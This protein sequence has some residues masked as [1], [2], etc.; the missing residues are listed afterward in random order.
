MP[1]YLCLQRSLSGVE[2]TESSEA[3]QGSSS[4][5]DM[6]EMYERFEEWREQYA[7]NIEDAGG[8]LAEGVFVTDATET[9]AS[10]V[11][12]G[13]L[14]GGYMILTAEDASEAMDVVGACPGLVGEQSGVEVIEIRT[15]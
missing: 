12:V 3:A 4:P 7:S 13:Q 10:F 2:G 6:Q 1:K 11:E 15:E 14:V 9:D 8:K 5:S